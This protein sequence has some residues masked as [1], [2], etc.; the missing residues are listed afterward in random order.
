MCIKYAL[1]QH[2]LH[3]HVITSISVMVVSGG[4]K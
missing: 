3:A 2:E 4:D 1:I